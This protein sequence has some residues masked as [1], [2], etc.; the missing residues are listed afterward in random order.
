M[1]LPQLAQLLL[2]LGASVS[3]SSTTSSLFD[4]LP[5]PPALPLPPPAWGISTL[6]Q[7]RSGAPGPPP[8]VDE[9]DEGVMELFTINGAAALESYYVDDSREGQ[10]SHYRYSA[11]MI[12]PMVDRAR[13][14][15]AGL[16]AGGAAARRAMRSLKKHAP[17]FEALEVHS[18]K[19]KDVAVVGSM[20]PWWEAVCVAFG[21]KSVTTIEY[22]ALDY[23]DTGNVIAT[24]T[25]AAWLAAPIAFD[26]VLSISSIDHD[27]LGRYNDP[28]AP[29]GD[30]LSMWWTQ[31]AMVKRTAEAFLLMTVPIGPDTVAW[32]LH[33]RYGKVRLPLLLRGW[34]VRAKYGWSDARLDAP[35]PYYK[36][37][38][39]VFVLG[40]AAEEGGSREL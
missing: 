20:E 36:S 27:G 24:T 21:A 34:D 23:A 3:S 10:G 19:G 16:A 14:L 12:D 6:R 25:P 26:A 40:V 17:I 31:S 4:T 1:A 7:R 29:D 22:N 33:R 9:L 32:N 30:L 13:E 39:P 38:E 11:A 5:L 8:R 18:I 2:F 37:Y 35:A 15:R 28:L